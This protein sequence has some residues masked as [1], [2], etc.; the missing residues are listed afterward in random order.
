[1][2]EDV[3]ELGK[4]QTLQGLRDYGKDGKPQGGVFGGEGLGSDLYCKTV[5]ALYF[6]YLLGKKLTRETRTGCKEGDQSS[7]RQEMTVL[8]PG[9]GMV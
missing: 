5:F 3:K 4:D 7:R 8:T 9:P 2:K 6:L 1:M